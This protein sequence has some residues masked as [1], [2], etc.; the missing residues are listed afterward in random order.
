[1][2]FPDRRPSV[3][4]PEFQAT[5]VAL[6]L[7]TLAMCFAGVVCVHSS[8]SGS[9][10]AFP[11]LPD[12]L[13]LLLC[14]RP[15]SRDAWK[16]MGAHFAACAGAGMLLGKGVVPALEIG[17]TGSVDVLVAWMLV[18]RF[19]SR[20]DQGMR[21]HLGRVLAIASVSVPLSGAFGATAVHASHGAPWIDAFMR[22]LVAD[23]AGMVLVLVPGF[24]LSRMEREIASLRRMDGCFRRL[25]GSASSGYVL[26]D[27]GWRV[28]E[29]NGRFLDFVGEARDGVLGTDF[30]GWMDAPGIPTDLP[31]YLGTE[32]WKDSGVLRYRRNDGR[33]CHG[34]TGF[35]R[36]PG[37]PMSLLVE[38][39]DA[40]A[41]VERE[42]AS[43]MDGDLMRLLVD[44]MPGPASYWDASLCIR[45]ANRAFA[46]WLGIALAD[47][48]GRSL[49]EVVGESEYALLRPEIEA[50]FEGASRV[51]ER[52]E[53]RSDGVRF[54]RFTLVPDWR[55]GL[56]RG[57]RAFASD[58]SATRAAQKTSMDA[59]VRLRSVLDA[60]PG[61]AIVA[62]GITGTIEVFNDAAVRLLG[63]D[64]EDIMG[65]ASLADLHDREEIAE[66]GLEIL[67]RSG[68]IVGGFDVLVDAARN[69]T[70]ET[71]EWTFLAKDGARRRV[72]GAV[73]CLHDRLGRTSG[74]VVAARDVSREKD[75]LRALED[76]RSQAERA[77]ALKGEFVANMSHEMRTPM[78]AVLGMA[79]LL[80]TTN[81]SP[82]QRRYL[83]MIRKSGRSLLGILDE[84]L[85]FSKIEAGK[86]RI[87]PVPFQLD[88]VLEHVGGICAVAARGKGLELSITVDPEVPFELVG[89]PQRLQQV[90]VN[91]A[92]N[93][94]K[95]TPSGRVAIHVDLLSR[96]ASEA[97]IGFRIQDTGIGMT[98]AQQRMVFQPF[99]QG[100]GA[101]TRR[102]GG[103]GL[104]LAISK[105]LTE[106]MG[107]RLGLHSMLDVGTEFYLSLAFPLGGDVG[108][109]QRGGSLE[110]V[111]ILAIDDDPQTRQSLEWA[112][113]RYGWHL[114]AVGSVDDA[115]ER[116]RGSVPDGGFS[117]ILVD[118]A[119]AG[120]DGRDG[121]ALL[122][123]AHPGEIPVLQLS[124]FAEE[125][126]EDDGIRRMD[127]LLVKPVTP[128]AL[129]DSIVAALSQDR[130]NER[131]RGVAMDE[132]N[133]E[134]SALEG[135]RVLL[136]EDNAFN[137]VVATETLR[138]LG[139][140]V[141]IAE[142]GKVACER[143]ETGVFDLVL[144]D[145]QMP[146]MDGY[147]ASRRIRDEMKLPVPILAMTAGVLPSDRDRCLEAG[148]DDFVTKPFQV[149][150][151][152]ET[153][154]RH[155][156][157]KNASAVAE[158]PD[159]PVATGVFEP[160]RMVEMLG[161]GAGGEAIVR[162]LVG[163]FLELT[164]KSLR[165]GR[166]ALERG[167]L[168]EAERAYHNLKSTSAS[169]GALDL[170]AVSKEMELL[171]VEKGVCPEAEATLA[172]VED[173][174][175][176]V[177][178][179]ARLW[180][181]S[182][183]N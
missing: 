133:G 108:A 30:R 124:G 170:S 5:K 53:K 123:S 22:W 62:T 122:R 174:F 42:K 179:L 36:L 169:L 65:R 183:R 88:D 157:P 134:R 46:D 54:M 7:A 177:E 137:Q 142:N 101:T 9:W 95:F 85:D 72:R 106:M 66:M 41:A 99:A 32:S 86:L 127:G 164:P 18:R 55:D 38:V 44:G 51:F 87:D 45:Y 155:V 33:A 6:S 105:R 15:P 166:E 141:E 154:L 25:L 143:L 8:R 171:L 1:M 110:D 167:D 73:A 97:E 69:G 40:T 153:I 130:T 139:A 90:L 117:A 160:M 76:A 126:Q 81:L 50:V 100:D 132:A 120:W 59:L 80:E 79:Q 102:F 163:Q 125:R 173:A 64:A 14:L 118:S 43:R 68:R 145:V 104:G 94:V 13:A 93:A 181:D 16:W 98:D 77:S 113:V 146:V 48:T 131:E 111:R 161:T 148:M 135:V 159:A 92:G 34:A 109:R 175:A 39:V 158:G 138:I 140:I 47:A 116:L 96:G 128:R 147:A 75:A 4:L 26:I 28:L 19:A 84:I 112:A 107:G 12:A 70:V 61:V 114:V 150:T 58:V 49:R 136:V 63:H 115:L 121:I 91:L 176:R 156:A 165:N 144:M 56:V 162:K 57:I 29:V 27:G 67:A 37:E 60:V 10:L 74:F 24:V 3:A 31:E 2:N 20:P 151:L 23:G 52:E 182:G 83:D 119:I 178:E 17:A 71:R 89:D 21:T 35:A 180:L 78:N 103:T 152:V 149:D 11:W 172:R 168:E 129:R 82:N